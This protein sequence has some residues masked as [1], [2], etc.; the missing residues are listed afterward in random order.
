[1]VPC[2]ALANVPV[3]SEHYAALK[4]K[5]VVYMYQVQ[6]FLLKKKLIISVRSSLTIQFKI[7]TPASQHFRSSD[8]TL[9]FSITPSTIYHNTYYVI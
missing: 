3:Y 9:F 1:M 4:K 6:D 2:D 8:P 7:V 5:E